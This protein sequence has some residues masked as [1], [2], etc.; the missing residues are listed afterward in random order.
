MQMRCG[1]LVE[2]FAARD[3]GDALA[4]ARRGPAVH[5]QRRGD[6][7]LH[8]IALSSRR[9]PLRSGADRAET[10]LFSRVS[11]R[12]RRFRRRSDR[13]SETYLSR[14]KSRVLSK[15]QFDVICRQN[16]DNNVSLLH[17]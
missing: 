2:V 3:G 6:R 12:P 14:T 5:I 1:E 7:R 13:P 16:D 15:Q 11:S 9:R 8:P 17:N 4:A 10:G